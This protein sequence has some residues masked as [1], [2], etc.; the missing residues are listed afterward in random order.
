M[1]KLI[2]PANAPLRDEAQSGGDGGGDP[3]LH[4]AG[5]APPEL[6]VRDFARERIEPPERLIAGRHDVGVAGEGE[7]GLGR[8]EPRIKVEDRG[9]SR[10]LE[11]DELGGETGLAQEI[12]QVGQR[13]ARQS[14]SPR[15]SG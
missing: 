5:A 7:I 4:V 14:A 2:E 1:R 11:R 9:R 12:A 8:A 10:R 6:A 13:A 15:E 3:A